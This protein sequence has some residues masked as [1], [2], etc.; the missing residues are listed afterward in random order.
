MAHRNKREYP[1]ANKRHRQ[2]EFQQSFR[3][4][5]GLRF[6]AEGMKLWS[7]TRHPEKRLPLE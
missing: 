2:K 3:E 5:V 7:E 4:D 6:D 1:S